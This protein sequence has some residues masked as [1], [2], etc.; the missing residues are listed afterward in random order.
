MF[1][2]I[3]CSRVPFDFPESES[4]LVSGYSVEYS[5]FLFVDLL[6]S[7]L[8]LLLYVYYS[9]FYLVNLFICCIITWF[10]LSYCLSSYFLELYHH[11]YDL[12]YCIAA[13]S[14]LDYD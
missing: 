13:Y 6:V 12:I 7:M 9:L 5:G 3:D 1:S 4:E 10:I 8:K 11:D 2:A 14:L